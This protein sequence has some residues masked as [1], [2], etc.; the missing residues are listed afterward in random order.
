MTDERIATVTAD[1]DTELSAWD[2]DTLRAFAEEIELAG[3]STTTDGAAIQ[4]TRAGKPISYTQALELMHAEIGRRRDAITLDT[5]LDDIAFDDVG[6]SIGEHLISTA[7]VGDVDYGERWE[8]AW[9]RVMSAGG[10]VKDLRDDLYGHF[11]TID[12]SQAWERYVSSQTV[13]EWLALGE[14]ATAAA[15]RRAP[16]R[17]PVP[18]R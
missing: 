9:D 14:P 15:N 18:G 6:A 2:I 7:I 4:W 11:W 1:I 16:D 5:P 3:E 17:R 8:A 10:T 12:A 13:A